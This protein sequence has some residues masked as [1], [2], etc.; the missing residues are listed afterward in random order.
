MNA[1]HIAQALNGRRIKEGSYSCDCPVADHRRA[2]MVVTDK[3]ETEPLIHC[4]AGCSFIDLKNEL[5]SRGLW[6]KKEYTAKERYEFNREVE[7]KTREKN[8]IWMAA[9]E[10][11][12]DIRTKNDDIKYKRLKGK[13]K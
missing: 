8:R 1:E 3:G 11:S 5:D 4:F 7:R 13:Y 2:K 6:P 12:A 10:G 9:Y